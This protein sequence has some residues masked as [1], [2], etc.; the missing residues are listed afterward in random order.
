M[1]NN[2]IDQVR[3][4][5][6][7]AALR[8]PAFQVIHRM[9]DYRPG[10]QLLATAVALQAMAEAAGISLHDLFTVAGNVMRDAE[11]PFTHHV[12]AI[13]DY[14]KGELRRDAL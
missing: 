13:R 12:Q 10:V 5:S 3:L 1:L 14:A 4:V 2:V 9:Q 11:G 8:V 6:S 7:P